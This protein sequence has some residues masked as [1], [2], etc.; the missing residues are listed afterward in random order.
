MIR[1]TRFRPVVTFLLLGRAWIFLCPSPLKGEEVKSSLIERRRSLSVTVGFGPGLLDLLSLVQGLPLFSSAVRR[2]CN[3]PRGTHSLES[4]P[5][6]G[7]RGNGLTHF[8]HLPPRKT[9]FF[10]LLSKRSSFSIDSSS[11]R[12]LAASS[13]DW[14][15]SLFRLL[16]E[17]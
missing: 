7:A 3:L 10:R 16:R 4:I 13:S 17:D 2:P 11:I 5:D 6:A 15:G 8:V 9:P 12:L 14:K 1:K